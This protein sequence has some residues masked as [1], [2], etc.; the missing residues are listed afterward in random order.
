MQI[1]PK[2]TRKKDMAKLRGRVDGD[3]GFMNAHQIKKV[4]VLIGQK[5]TPVWASSDTEVRK[6]LLRSF[7]KLA[8]N[9]AQ[10]RAAARWTQAI[11]LVYRMSLPYN[12]AALEMDITV[13]ALRSML[14]NI[15]RSARGQRANG[16][17]AK[18]GK[19]GRPKSK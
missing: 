13:G 7:P 1:D 19:R 9:R 18:N 3:D 2:L 12:H 16:S 8:T 5:D 4:R 15:R 14:R 6:I 11:V 10:R 17:G